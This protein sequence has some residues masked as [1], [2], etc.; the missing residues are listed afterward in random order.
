[1]TLFKES[2]S[3]HLTAGPHDRI[4]RDTCPGQAHFAGTGPQFKTCRECAHWDHG[5]PHDY[6][7]RRAK[8]G[9]LI[10]SARC[11][12]YRALTNTDGD[13]V[14]DDARACKHF[15]HAA[16]VPARFAKG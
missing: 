14:P 13:K 1:M 15:S 10:K 12:K 2:L 8:F 6:Y 16:I 4:A 5:G 11:R 3:D 9:G 7:S